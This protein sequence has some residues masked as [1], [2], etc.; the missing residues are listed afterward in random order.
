MWHNVMPEYDG[1]YQTILLSDAEE[2]LDYILD[3]S[4]KG[5]IWVAT[6]DE[7]VKYI[8]EKQN[9]SLNTY[10]LDGKIYI[11]AELTD[12]R[13][14]YETFDQPLTVIIDI[15]DD[16]S[17]EDPSSEHQIVTEVVPGKEYVVDISG[18]C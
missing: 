9:I 10:I 17:F 3:L 15:S 16:Y 8:R 2:H 14:S 13:M 4:K 1:C 11:Y 6:Y 18:D 12:D 5:S 7:A